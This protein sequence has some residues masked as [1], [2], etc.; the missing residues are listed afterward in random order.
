MFSDKA[1]DFICLNHAVVSVNYYLCSCIRYKRI[2][3]TIH[4]GETLNV[5]SRLAVA[6]FWLIIIAVI[7]LTCLTVMLI[8]CLC[9]MILTDRCLIQN[10][11]STLVKCNRHL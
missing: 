2:W 10:R 11:F 5:I 9:T 4:C 1:L 3:I 8:N 7:R 6:R